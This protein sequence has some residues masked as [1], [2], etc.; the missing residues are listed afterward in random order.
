MKKIPFV[1]LRPMHNM[2][3]KQLE[4]AFN[5]VTF[6]NSNFIMGEECEAFEHEF[7]AY[8]GCKY[9]VGCGNGL[10]ALSLPLRALGIG[11]GDEVILPDNTF[12]ATALAVSQSGATPVFVDPA[13]GTFN[14]NPEL[15]EEKITKNTRAIMPVHLYGRAADMGPIVYIAKKY[16]LR[17]VEDCAQAHGAEYKGKRIG[18]FGDAAG[19]SFYP[20]KNLG[21]LGDGG[22]VVTDDKDIAG[23]V[24]MLRNYGSSVKYNHEYAGVNSRLDELQAAFL[25]IK[26]PHLDEWNK[27]RNR[28]ASKIIDNVNNPLIRLPAKSDDTYYNVWHIFAVM[29]E[30]RDKLEKYLDSKGIGYNMHYPIPVHLQKAYAYLNL[31]KGAYPVAEKNSACE[32]SLPMY[33]GLTDEQIDYIIDALNNFKG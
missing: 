27:E 13:E 19:F 17:I 5:R 23:K 28:I 26:L 21:A 3:R 4:E 15:I 22:I 20:G 6:E 16:N 9:A 8:C 30:C 18:S 2:L 33:W 29:C 7:A 1:S 11:P 10:D 32:L 31:P 24:R 14:I 25:R 12:V